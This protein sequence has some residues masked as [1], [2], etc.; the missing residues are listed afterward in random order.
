MFKQRLID[1]CSHEWHEAI[2]NSSKLS[3]YSSFKS[4]LEP[5]KYMHCI[6]NRSYRIA[7]AKFRCSNHSLYIESGRKQGIDVTERTCKFCET[8]SHSVIEDEYHFLCKCPLYHNQRKELL[9]NLEDCTYY[10]F[11]TVMSSS[12]YPIINSVAKFIHEANVTRDE[13]L[14][15][16]NISQ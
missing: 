10:E 11:T 8:I 6:S 5:E 14:S 4:L 12:K 2:N 7:L 1:N 9:P 13:F 16:N 15:E 3:T